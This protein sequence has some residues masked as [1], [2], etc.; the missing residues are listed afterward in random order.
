MTNRTMVAMVMV[1]GVAGLVLGGCSTADNSTADTGDDATG[2]ETCKSM[3]ASGDGWCDSCSKG[4]VKGAEVA[5]KG[6]Y[7]AKTGGPACTTCKKD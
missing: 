3:M 5:C 4:M 1:L 7:G 6:C 2:C